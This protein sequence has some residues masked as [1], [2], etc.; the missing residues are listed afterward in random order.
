MLARGNNK[1]NAEGQSQV[2]LSE[3]PH[4]KILKISLWKAL[5]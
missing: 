3:H 5:V 2:T 1:I 4:A